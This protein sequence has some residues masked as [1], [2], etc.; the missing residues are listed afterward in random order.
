MLERGDVELQAERRVEVER[1]LVQP[2]HEVVVHRSKKASA[3][4]VL[5]EVSHRL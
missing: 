3:A 1:R 5:D 2:V 4:G